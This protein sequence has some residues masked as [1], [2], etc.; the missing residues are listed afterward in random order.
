MVHVVIL[1]YA[2][3]HVMN[4]VIN[5]DV[6]FSYNAQFTE[7]LNVH[8]NI[9]IQKMVDHYKIVRFD[10]YSLIKIYFIFV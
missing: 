7:A 10:K 3:N 8:M 5:L 6:I 4:K 2:S 9:H 1:M